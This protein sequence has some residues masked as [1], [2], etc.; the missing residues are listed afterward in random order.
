MDWFII[1]L[2]VHGLIG[3]TDVLMNHEW[4]A[5]LPKQAGAA[6][7]QRL[8]SVRELIFATLFGA[9]A[10]REWHGAL[11]WMILALF[12]TE[13]VVSIVDTVLEWRTRVLP[14]PERVLHVLLFVNLGA[15]V[16]LTGQQLVLWHA[17]PT[18]LT[19]V[20]Y[21]ALSWVLSALSAAAL[22]W[23]IRDAVSAQR[24]GRTVRGTVRGTVQGPTELR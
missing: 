13:L 7:E 4:L 10:W 17:L 22:G 16:V 19:P 5:R 11:A 9:L 21:G 14:V 8:H 23:S 12:A 20:S 6:P 18:G 3:S 15:L 24:L 2:L 1:A